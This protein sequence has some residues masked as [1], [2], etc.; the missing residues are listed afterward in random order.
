MLNMSLRAI[1][2]SPLPVA[3]LPV[4]THL[5][6]EFLLQSLS[7]GMV[8]GQLCFEVIH[9]QGPVKS[10]QWKRGDLSKINPAISAEA[11][12]RFD[13]LIE[14]GTLPSIVAAFFDLYIGAMEAQS[15]DIFNKLL[16]IADKNKQHLKAMPVEWAQAHTL[17]IVESKKYLVRSWVKSVCDNYMFGSDDTNATWEAPNFLIMEPLGTPRPGRQ[18]PFDHDAAWVRFDCAESKMP[19]EN[20]EWRYGVDIGSAVDRAAGEASVSMM[21]QAIPPPASEIELAKLRNLDD[22]KT[23]STLNL[24]VPTA[25]VKAKEISTSKA[26]TQER[27]GR[28][29]ARYK[30]I[31]N[32][33]RDMTDVA[34]AKKIAAERIGEGKSY[35]TIRHNMKP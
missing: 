8:T 27:Y 4:L 22:D 13:L 15:V 35:N 3:L 12:A 23:A 11:L 26:K 33:N 5:R 17:Q 7:N 19:L 34:I 1:L 18:K 14:C 9:F 6:Q 28:W 29:M 31:S 16:E 21:M 30:E 20:F 32:A 10:C 24:S 2:D 25:G